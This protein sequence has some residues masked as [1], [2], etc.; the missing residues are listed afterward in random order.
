MMS[1]YPPEASVTGTRER[2]VWS[3]SIDS[4]SSRAG[5]RLCLGQ[6][7]AFMVVSSVQP[8]RYVPYPLYATSL[9]VFR[10]V[11]HAGS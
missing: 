10:G 8:R 6:N 7:H 11:R 4:T 1:T 2:E 5:T 9:C 3:A